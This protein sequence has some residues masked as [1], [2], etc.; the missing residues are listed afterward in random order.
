[1]RLQTAQNLWK[2]WAKARTGSG[3][4]RK[5]VDSARIELVD[6]NGNNVGGSRTL[7]GSLIWVKK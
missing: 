2:T 5:D 7:G 4:L 1:M 3:S 6:L